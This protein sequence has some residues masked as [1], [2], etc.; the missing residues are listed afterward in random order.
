MNVAE[1]EIIM[2]KNKSSSSTRTWLLYV[3]VV[4]LISASGAL[5]YR[6]ISNKK[7][8]NKTSDRTSSLIDEQFEEASKHIEETRK[9]ISQDGFNNKFEIRAGK[10]SGSST[11]SVMTEII[12]NNKK[13]ADYQISVVFDGVDCGPDVTCIAEQKDKVVTWRGHNLAYY[14]IS[15]DYDTDGYINKATITTKE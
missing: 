7:S 13:N 6:I 3:M 11:E 4:I 12:T 14:E 10:S 15:Y 8:T 1:K 5:I 9:K 2:T